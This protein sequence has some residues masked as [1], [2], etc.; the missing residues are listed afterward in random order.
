MNLKHSLKKALHNCGMILECAST[1]I[2]ASGVSLRK[3]VNLNHPF[4]ELQK[5]NYSGCRRQPST[6][7]SQQSSIEYFFTWKSLIP[8]ISNIKSKN[9][10]PGIV[11]NHLAIT[12]FAPTRNICHNQLVAS[13][14]L[15]KIFVGI[16]VFSQI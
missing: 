4:R 3:S 1:I 14:Q 10:Y 7:N 8:Y 15:V 6:V 12:K 9:L 16:K 5:I 13:H 11:K 2:P